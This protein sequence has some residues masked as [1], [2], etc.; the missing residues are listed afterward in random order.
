MRKFS[1]L[2]KFSAFECLECP[3]DAVDMIEPFWDNT[4]EEGMNNGTVRRIRNRGMSPW[5]RLRSA[6]SDWP[7]AFWLC[8]PRRCRD[9]SRIMRFQRFFRGRFFI[10]FLLAAGDVEHRIWRLGAFGKSTDELFLSADCI[11]EVA[12]RV[13]GIADP[14]LCTRCQTRI[15]VALQE[16]IETGNS[17][18]I[19]AIL[20]LTISGLIREAFS[21]FRS[22]NTGRR[23]T[24]GRTETLTGGASL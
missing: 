15:R 23:R 8:Q 9:I 21:A 17:I 13:V 6:I 3:S 12:Q 5:H 20:E 16:F 14:V 18:L 2:R 7:A 1:V 4:N 22:R 10:H 19:P 24:L 11:L